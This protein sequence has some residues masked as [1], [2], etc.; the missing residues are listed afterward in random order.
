MKPENAVCGIDPETGAPARRYTVTG[1]GGRTVTVDLCETHAAPLEA[2]LARAATPPARVP[3][4]LPDPAAG[5]VGTAP[6]QRP[7]RRRG[8]LRITTLEEIEALKR[9]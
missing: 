7:A 8:R 2:L 3:A 9:R 5:A 6:G 4:P 1:A